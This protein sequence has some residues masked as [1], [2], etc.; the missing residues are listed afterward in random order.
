MQFTVSLGQTF[1]HLQVC[2]PDLHLI[3]TK[4]NQG[5]QEING[6]IY[7]SISGNSWSLSWPVIDRYIQHKVQYLLQLCLDANAEV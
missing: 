4:I 6:E 1:F 7:E 5:I 3:A 2:F